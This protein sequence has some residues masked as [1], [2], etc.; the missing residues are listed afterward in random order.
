M[1]INKFQVSGN[2]GKDPEIRQV[3]DKKVA[4]FSL[5]A[6]ESYKDKQ[7]EW[8]NITDWF[9]IVVWGRKAEYVENYVKK[10]SNLYIEGQLKNRSWEDK[11]G[12]KRNS[13]EVM[14]SDFKGEIQFIGK[15]SDNEALNTQ[16]PTNTFD[17]DSPA[18]ENDLPF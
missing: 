13:I 12:N 15:K 17:S 2:V 3:G 6:T 11:E 18:D 10:G 8:Q 4:N 9:N 14:L 1:K 16:E 7:G 5:A